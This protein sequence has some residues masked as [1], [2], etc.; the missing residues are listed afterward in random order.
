MNTKSNV[1]HP[2]DHYIFLLQAADRSVMHHNWT[3]PETYTARFLKQLEW[4]QNC[5]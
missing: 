1:L 2:I 5:F 4:I 3:D